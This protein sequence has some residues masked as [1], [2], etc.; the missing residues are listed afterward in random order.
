[1]L[2]T[3]TIRARLCLI[4]LTSI[5]GTFAVL[6]FIIL[7]MREGHLG[8]RRQKT[9][10]LVETAVSLIQGEYDSFRRGEMPEEKAREHALRILSRLRYDG[11]NYFWVNDLDATLIMHPFEHEMVGNSMRETRDPHGVYM[12]REFVR[13]VDN[14]DQAGFVSYHWPRER[15]ADPSPK[16]SYVTLF[17]PWGWIIG[18]GIYVDDVNITLR[19]RATRGLGLA[20]L[21]LLIVVV[22]LTALIGRSLSRP[23]QQLA[24]GMDRL[25]QG[26]TEVQIPTGQGGEVGQ[27]SR[28]FA[29]FRDKTIENRKLQEERDRIQAEEIEE[30]RRRLQLLDVADGFEQSVAGIVTGVSGASRTLQQSADKMDNIARDAVQKS[31]HVSSSAKTVTGNME[32]VASATRALSERT[33]DISR[34]IRDS[35]TVADVAREKA[36]TA[37]ERVDQLSLAASRIGE[38][39]FLINDIADQTNLLALN[40]TIEAARAGEAGRGFAVVAAEVKSL[41][42]QTGKATDQIVDQ[43]RSVQDATGKAVEDIVGIAEVIDRI[44]ETTGT[45]SEAVRQQDE[46]TRDIS[47]NIQTA[48]AGAQEIAQVV[49]SL[50]DAAVETGRA[51][52]NVLEASLAVSDQSSL[53]KEEVDRFVS[54]VRKDG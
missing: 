29:V 32:S 35:S 44:S 7:E 27:F 6:A 22:P 26:E 39:I 52:G 24:G 50:R 13:A 1:M 8:D 54:T 9:R 53:L 2:A 21:V 38:I 25:C 47:A 14:P 3:L 46:A 17:E 48:T 30:H 41:A 40:A 19:E 51:S 4:V 49:A 33:G 28:A 37:R 23:M 34:Q 36:G 20:L 12:F 15:G 18:T 43:I 45:I 42:E 5:L 31:D 16:I 11:N 10:E